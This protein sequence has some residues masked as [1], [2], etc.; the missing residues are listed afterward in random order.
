MR[1]AVAGPHTHLVARRVTSS[2]LIGRGNE[3]TAA[4]DA[5][6]SVH[7]GQARMM[8]IAGDAGIGKTRLVT[9]LCSRAG[10]AGMLTARWGRSLPPVTGNG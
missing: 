7:R 3:L 6:T 8:L 2:A 9:E 4:V 10:Q 1:S 5:A